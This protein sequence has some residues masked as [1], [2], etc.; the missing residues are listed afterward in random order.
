MASFSG[1][2]AIFPQKPD[3]SALIQRTIH[4]ITCLIAHHHGFDEAGQCAF[5]MQHGCWPPEKEAKEAANAGSVVPPLDEGDDV[6]ARHCCSLN[7]ITQILRGFIF[8]H[9]LP[10]LDDEYVNLL[11]FGRFCNECIADRVYADAPLFPEDDWAASFALVRNVLDVVALL[12]YDFL[13]L[14]EAEGEYAFMMYGNLSPTTTRVQLASLFSLSSSSSSSSSTLSACVQADELAEPAAYPSPESQPTECVNEKPTDKREPP[15]LSLSNCLKRLRHRAPDM[16]QWS[17][18]QNKQDYTSMSQLEPVF[19]FM[20]WNQMDC[21]EV[22]KELQ[23]H[24]ASL[25]VP[26]LP[27]S[28]AADT[29]PDVDSP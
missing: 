13:P 27:R 28:T 16:F 19:R 15:R 17:L 2:L 10:P 12:L 20:Q 18:L 23:Q 22:M 25:P 14:H 3:V 6:D 24:V 11:E 26:P 8:E 9:M 1:S 29:V 21:E 5:F 7:A 4:T